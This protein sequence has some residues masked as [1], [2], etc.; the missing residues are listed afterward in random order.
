MVEP[1]AIVIAN[2]TASFYNAQITYR[3]DY[4]KYIRKTSYFPRREF[5]ILWFLLLNT[6]SYQLKKC[7]P[8]NG[9]LKP[10]WTSVASI[11]DRLESEDLISWCATIQ[12]TLLKGDFFD[13]FVRAHFWSWLLY[14]ILIYIIRT[15]KFIESHYNIV[16]QHS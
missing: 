11:C 14:Q 16:K 1:L 6:T 2:S 10:E 9:L 13:K 12:N 15:R 7:F 8:T 5:I 4:K 3:P